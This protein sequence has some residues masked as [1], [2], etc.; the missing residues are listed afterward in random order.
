[1][2]FILG[3]KGTGSLPIL[4]IVIPVALLLGIAFCVY[5]IFKKRDNVIP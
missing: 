3:I 1:M 4:L 2:I 5:K